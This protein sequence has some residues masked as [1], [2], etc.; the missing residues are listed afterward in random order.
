[1]SEYKRHHPKQE[2]A[3]DRTAEYRDGVERRKGKEWYKSAA[4]DGM[5]EA[6]IGSSGTERYS[7]AEVRAEVREGGKDE[8]YYRKLKADGAK[9]NGN[10]QDYLYDTFGIQFGIH[11]DGGRHHGKPEGG[12]TDKEPT[13]R[14]VTINPP[15]EE[16][17]SD[18]PIGTEPPVGD[19]PQDFL[20][21]YIK[22]SFNA[23]GGTLTNTGDI[24]AE[25]DVTLDNS[26]TNKNKVNQIANSSFIADGY[27]LDLG[28]LKL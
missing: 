2:E 28:E 4:G 10:A 24:T 23:K 16:E 9:F 5:H 21:Q 14:S 12:D 27:K 15:K 17:V 26:V 11:K 18:D 7:G 13:D 6:H 8:A 25:G 1:M 3:Y 20:G 19:T 22:N